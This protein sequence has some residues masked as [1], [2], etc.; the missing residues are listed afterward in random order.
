MVY[1]FLGYSINELIFNPDPSEVAGI[2][3]LSLK[4]FL[5]D[6]IVSKQKINTSYMD[7]TEVFGFNIDNYFVWGATAMVLSEL[8]DMIKKV[9]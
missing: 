1:P 3:E 8:K 9:L 5:D 7:D 6:T 4:N 2:V